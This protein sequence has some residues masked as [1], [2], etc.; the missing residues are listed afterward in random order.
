MEVQP[1]SPAMKKQYDFSKSKPN[2]YAA[3]LRKQVTL[4]LGHGRAG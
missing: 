1:D 2:P 3:R 4:R